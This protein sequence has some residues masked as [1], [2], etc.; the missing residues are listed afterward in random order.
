MTLRRVNRVSWLPLAF[1]PRASIE[2]DVPRY[3]PGCPR[4]GQ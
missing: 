2:L 3:S 1:S 4:C